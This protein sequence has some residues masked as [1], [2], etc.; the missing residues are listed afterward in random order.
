MLQLHDKIMSIYHQ[1]LSSIYT[2]HL[3]LEREEQDS[4][5]ERKKEK[6]TP[7]IH[8]RTNEQYYTLR[9]LNELE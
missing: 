7:T 2:I 9:R 5:R 8:K 4:L 3:L 6:Q 1:I